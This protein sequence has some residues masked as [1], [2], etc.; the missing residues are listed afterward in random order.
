MDGLSQATTYRRLLASR[1]AILIVLLLKPFTF[2][3]TVFATI[4]TS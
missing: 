3:V 1:I 2:F 4:V